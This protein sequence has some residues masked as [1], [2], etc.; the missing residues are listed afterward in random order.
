MR[1]LVA[2]FFGSG[3]ILRQVRDTDRGSGTVASLVAAGLAY[4]V[5][6]VWGRA[7]ILV[8]VL[9]TG[10]WAVASLRF[11]DDPGWVVVDE[12]SGML[13]ASLGLGL[14]GLLVAFVV[15]R[16]A[17]IKKTWFPGVGRAEGLPGAWG[18]M[19]DDL[20]AGSYG[21]AAGW[22]VTVLSAA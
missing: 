16:L 12:A 8:A 19:A 9:A 4:L 15:F 2:S 5:S 11:E 22:A 14:T 20:V 21:L 13:L 3:F 10:F 6:P 7:A 1:K 18:I 17:D